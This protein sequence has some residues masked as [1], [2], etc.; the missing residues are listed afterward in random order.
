[1]APSAPPTSGPRLLVRRVLGMGGQAA[2]EIAATVRRPARLLAV[3]KPQK[4]R[5]VLRRMVARGRTTSLD[6]RWQ[7][8]GTRKDLSARHYDSYDSYVEHQ[9]TKLSTLDL[10][11]YQVR[12]RAALRERLERN[13]RIEAPARVLCL[14]ARLGAEVMAFHDLKHLAIGVDLNPGENNPYVLP[15]DFHD[16]VFPD[17]CFDLV[18]TN[19]LDHV[20]DLDRMLGEIDRVLA[21]EGRLLI[22]VPESSGRGEYEVLSWSDLDTLQGELSARGWVEHSRNPFEYPGAGWQIELLRRPAC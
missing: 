16:L 22:E 17:D 7:A 2:K 1:M 14:G 20:L 12:F 19:T 6:A 18:F 15:G 10:T 8:V 13:L 3:L 4:V 21:P 5:R 9:K 11:T